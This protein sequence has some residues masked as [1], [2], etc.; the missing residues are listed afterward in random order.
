LRGALGFA[1]KTLNA[2][3]L[4]HGVRPF[5]PIRR[6]R[7]IIQRHGADIDTDA[8]SDA[9]IP[10]YGD[11]GSVNSK[12]VR[13][14][15]TPIFVSVVF[16]YNFSFGLKIMVYRQKIHHINSEK[17]EILVFLQMI[18]MCSTIS[19]SFVAEQNKIQKHFFP[20]RKLFYIGSYEAVL[21]A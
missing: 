5:L 10:V 6:L 1:G 11:V 14:G 17:A 7:P 8:V 12:F 21:Y 9:D 20:K 16:A 19:L 15:G 2:V 3:G 13:F 18:K 4:A